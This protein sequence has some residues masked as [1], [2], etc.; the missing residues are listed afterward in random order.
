MS[1]HS[2]RGHF[3]V[4]EGG[5]GT[6]KSTQVRLLADALDALMTREPGGTDIGDRLRELW[7]DP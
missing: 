5:D 4:F 6:G 2:T 1:A 7:L 3:I